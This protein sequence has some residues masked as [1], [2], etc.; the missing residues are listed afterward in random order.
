MNRH[1]HLLA[2]VVFSSALLADVAL[3]Q[4]GPF[5]VKSDEELQL[6]RKKAAPPVL[7]I[8]PGSL[9]IRVAKGGKATGQIRVS[10]GGGGLLTF[11]VQTSLVGVHAVPSAGELG[12]E[13]DAEVEVNVSVEA[14]P[15]GERLGMLTVEA[16]GA[17]GSP[18]H[19]P[20]TLDIYQPMPEPPADRG[21]PAAAAQALE[22][23]DEP[24]DEFEPGPVF[25][26]VRRPS[27]RGRYSA[28]TGLAFPAQAEAGTDP[29]PL[30]GVSARLLEYEAGR[31]EVGLDIGGSAD[32]GR[33][34]STPVTV[35]AL[36]L[37]GSGPAYV[38][39][40]GSCVIELVSD[41]VSGASYTN[42]AVG[43]NVGAGY[44]L[45]DKVD[46]RGVYEVLVFSDNAQGVAELTVG[47]HF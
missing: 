6:E 45:R 30:L 27:P 43:L 21:E 38:L 32:V 19:V 35:R 8:A 12:Y 23:P 39:A 34:T 1:A 28:R 16:A 5:M 7:E 46:F 29:I 11:K 44:V 9:S 13:Q 14:L 42:G 24:P 22:T 10:N 40:G 25:D 17:R 37:I 41:D 20:L 31:L 47:Y 15:V 2:C 26:G 4:A 36:A 33:Y 18:T 3:A